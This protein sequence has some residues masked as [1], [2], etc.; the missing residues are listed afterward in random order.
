LDIQCSVRDFCLSKG[1]VWS[2]GGG[3]RL[4]GVDLELGQ[5]RKVLLPPLGGRYR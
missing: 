1:K 5:R 3:A 4:R 2:K